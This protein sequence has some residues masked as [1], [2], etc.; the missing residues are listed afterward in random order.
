MKM[1]K[2]KVTMTTT[3]TYNVEAENPEEANQKLMESGIVNPFNEEQ[4]D[5][6]YDEEYELIETKDKYDPEDCDV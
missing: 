4:R 2:I 5:E 6:D 3:K 1:H